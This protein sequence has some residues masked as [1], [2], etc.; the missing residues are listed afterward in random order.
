[1]F[2]DVSRDGRHRA[3]GGSCCIWVGSCSW[4]PDIFF[5]F[6]VEV[7]HGFYWNKRGFGLFLKDI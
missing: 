5:R 2:G 6:F 4:A 1:M 3:L 7:Y